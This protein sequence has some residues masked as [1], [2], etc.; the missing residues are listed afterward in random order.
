[1]VAER[2]EDANRAATARMPFIVAWIVVELVESDL[3]SD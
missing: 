2:P 3:L 1:M